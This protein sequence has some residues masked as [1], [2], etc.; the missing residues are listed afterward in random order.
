MVPQVRVD[1]FLPGVGGVG[2]GLVIR[3]G[4]AMAVGAT[5]T[6]AVPSGATITK[7]RF[8]SD[9]QCRQSAVR[10]MAEITADLEG[11]RQPLRLFYGPNVN[12]KIER[13]YHSEEAALILAHLEKLQEAAA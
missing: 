13:L 2:H 3:E 10:I 7:K 6:V 5:E 1:C 4:L 9:A 8:L 12:E 11:K